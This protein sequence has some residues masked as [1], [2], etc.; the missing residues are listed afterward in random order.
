MKSLNDL[1][2]IYERTLVLPKVKPEPQFYLVS[3][4][5][6]GSGKSTVLKRLSEMLGLVRI[7][8]DDIRKVVFENEG[9]EE[10]TW[11]IGRRV[12]EKYVA[13]GYSIAHDTDGAT[14]KTQAAIAK[15]AQE[16]GVKT[17]WVHVNPPESFILANLDRP[18][19]K[20]LFESQEAARAKYLERKKLHENLD[21]QFAFEFDPSRSD[22]EL[23]IEQAAAGIQGLL[24]A[25]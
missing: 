13:Q 19:P 23:Q 25:Q 12:V 8:G 2:E 6:M 20:W 18:K 10:D 14:A 1:A 22:F 17:V 3:V 21:I 9:N 7:C 5:L 16:Y 24:L 11:E 15:Q 4:G